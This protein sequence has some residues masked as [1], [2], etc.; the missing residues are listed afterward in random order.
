MV[1]YTKKTLMPVDSRSLFNW[2]ESEGA[3]IRLSPPWEHITLIRKDRS[4]KPGSEVHFKLKKGLLSLR[5]VA[6]HTDYNPP[7][8]FTD[9]QIKG[10]FKTWIHRHR[11]IPVDP[12]VSELED[13]IT[14]RLP[15][16]IGEHLALRT[17]KRMFQYRHDVLQHDLQVQKAFPNMPMTIAITGSSGM[18]GSALSAF[19]QTAGHKVIPIVRH[20]LSTHA[21]TWDP[22]KRE[23]QQ[24]KLEGIDAVINLSGENIGSGRWTKDK[25]KRIYESRII[26]TQLLA[27]TL[28]HLK[29]PPRV[30]ISAS[31]TGY[32]GEDLKEACTESKIP[33]KG[34]LAYLCH[35]WEAAAN[36]FTAGRCVTPRFGAVLSSSG[37][38]LKKMLPAFRTGLG[39]IIGD[40]SQW[41][42]WIALDDLIYSLYRLLAENQFS[43]PVNLCSPYPVTNR[44]LTKTLGKILS[45]PTIL[46]IPKFAI[47][48]GFGEM[49]DATL[50]SSCK[51]IPK[52]LQTNNHTFYYPFFEEAVKHTLGRNS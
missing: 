42:S 44:E 18:I 10:P 40:G 7:N 28:N 33:G 11:M 37:G 17:I 35:E 50:L 36:L 38:M 46:S 51:A 22:I 31:A 24:E 34:F 3:F 45:R 5:W 25:K 48:M 14:F 4:L 26:S 16:S 39:S 41:V 9:I 47:R 27:E 52:A 2:H 30:F 15:G 49:A 43:G 29:N 8:E 13:N 32:Y 19:L 1:E 21:I 6:R 23:I 12:S 20:T